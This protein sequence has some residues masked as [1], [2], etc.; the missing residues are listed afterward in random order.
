ML[1]ACTLI[2]HLPDEVSARTMAHFGVGD[3]SDGPP[4]AA[5]LP[6]STAAPIVV[7]QDSTLAAKLARY[8]PNLTN[9]S[10]AGLWEQVS[11]LPESDNS[12]EPCPAWVANI[13]LASSILFFAVWKWRRHR[14]SRFDKGVAQEVS[15]QRRLFDDASRGL[16]SGKQS[17]LRDFLHTSLK[18]IAC[19]V[20]S[21]GLSAL[22][23]KYV[24]TSYI[25]CGCF[26]ASGL[27][28][29][30]QQNQVLNEGQ[31]KLLGI[32]FVA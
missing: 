26:I 10:L 1:A 12:Q 32:D 29:D 7:A 3:D 30:R 25:I 16:L 19:L 8:L 24:D 23:L 5:S 28:Y 6:A 9:I 18:W 4:G 15:L 11:G 22:L 2:F 13:A 27:V 21:S 17:R 20:A 14:A 31:K